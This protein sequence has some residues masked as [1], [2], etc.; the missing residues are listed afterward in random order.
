MNWIIGLAIALVLS[1]G[2]NL[3]QWRDCD[4]EI[5]R[6]NGEHK[7]AIEKAQGDAERAARSAEAAANSKAAAVADSY[8]KG[9][10]DAQAAA[11]R[12][13]A[14]LRAGNL[15]LHKRWRA[16]ESRCVSATADSAGE[17]D[18]AADDA[19]ESASRIVRTVAEG[20][21]QTIALQDYI[22]RVCSPGAP[23]T[24]GAAH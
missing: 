10:T 9:K 8:E 20:Q 24:A 2:A 1:L 21:A 3:K 19:R 11:D 14:D 23:W 15:V 17:P 18:A 13:L 22:R 7:T 16:A 12:D 5:E 6:I 4:V